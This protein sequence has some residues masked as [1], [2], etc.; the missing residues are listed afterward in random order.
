MTPATELIIDGVLTVLLI[1][2]MGIFI[3][4]YRR[5]RDIK[6]GQS[7]LRDLVDSLNKAV[8]DA[9]TSVAALKHSSREV[10]GRLQ[11][12]VSR[13]RVLSDELAMITETGNNLA[14]RIEKGLTNGRDKPQASAAVSET[15]KKEQRELLA[16]LREA[17]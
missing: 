14:D 13:A 7:E 9:Q 1:A 3:A 11:T 15:G 17:R 6:D 4:V 16:A 8:V 12:E 5:L 10:E 2:V